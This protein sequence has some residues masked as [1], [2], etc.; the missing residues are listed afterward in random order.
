[1]SDQAP[2]DHTLETENAI[3]R[4]ER[5]NAASAPEGPLQQYY[6]FKDLKRLKIVGTWPT[7]Y[8]WIKD[9]G[10]PEGSHLSPRYRV[11]S[12]SEVHAWVESQRVKAA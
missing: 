2:I 8:A 4:R 6:R 11:W 7:L 3:R 10:F 9:R 5:D 12:A 1:M